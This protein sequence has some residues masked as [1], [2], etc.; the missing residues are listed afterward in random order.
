MNR[1]E[2]LL[3]IVLELQR[4]KRGY[5]RAKDLA[6]TFEVSQRTIYRDM[7]ALP[8]AGVPISVAEREGYALVEGY[9]L[10]PLRDCIVS[11]LVCQAIFGI[12]VKV[13]TIVHQCPNPLTFNR[14]KCMG[15]FKLPSFVHQR[16]T[17]QF[18]EV[19]GSNL[20]TATKIHTASHLIWP[21]GLK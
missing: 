12:Y 21:R 8:E 11:I 3:A 18:R 2:R 6:K 16:Y 7:L 20:G 10:P 5:Y 14:R 17:V 13:K 9:F 19:P 1:T 15:F 4:K